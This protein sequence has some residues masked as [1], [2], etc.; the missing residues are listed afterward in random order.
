MAM[1]PKKRGHN[2]QKIVTQMSPKSEI[3]LT[4]RSTEEGQLTNEE[5]MTQKRVSFTNQNLLE[6]YKCGAQDDES[7]KTR[8]PIEPSAGRMP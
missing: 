3:P 1:N 8:H 2:T 5:R 7:T 6:D 4:V